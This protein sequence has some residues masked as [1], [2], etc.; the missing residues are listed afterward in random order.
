[1]IEIIEIIEIEIII[2][3]IDRRNVDNSP[4]RKHV[5]RRRA[6]QGSFLAFCPVVPII[7]KIDVGLRQGLRS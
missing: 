3:E 4:V 2:I 7:L 5:V 1:M 6:K